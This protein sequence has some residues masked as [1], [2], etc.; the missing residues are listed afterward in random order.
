LIV[1]ENS[2]DIAVIT[3]RQVLEGAPVLIVEYSDGTWQ[4]ICG[5]T[6]DTT[7]G[8]VVGLKEILAMDTSLREP[9]ARLRSG[10][11]AQRSQVD[12]AWHYR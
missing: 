9:V 10:G 1:G 4:F 7:D 6:N 2:H 8:R 12:A 11:I 5:S 3:T